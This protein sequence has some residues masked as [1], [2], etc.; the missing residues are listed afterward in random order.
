MNKERTRFNKSLIGL[1][2]GIT[3]LFLSGAFAY[4]QQTDVPFV[5]TPEEVVMEMLKMA[6]V[7][8]NDLLYDLG[9]GDGRIVITAAKKFGCRGV[10]IDIDPQRIR[11]SR[12]NAIKEGVTDKVNFIQ[13]NLFNADISKATVVTL[14]LLSE[15]NLR[16]RPILF[17]Q[18]KPGTRVVSHEFSMGKWEADASTTVK[19][20][21]TPVVDYW[22]QDVEDYWNTHN[23]LFWIMPANVTGT[24][25]LTVPDI[26][27]KNEWVLKFNQEFQKVSGK[28]FEDNTEIPLTVE[29]G[30][31][32]GD[33]LH[34]TLERR[35]R[36]RMERMHFEGSVKDHSMNGI[37]TID[38]GRGNENT[39]WKATRDP[40]TLRPIHISD[41]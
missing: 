39:Q 10:G 32:N 15:V 2:A 25:E 24:W 41:Y 8:K 12:E 28:A 18:L 9:C 26:T 29:G 3:L 14:Y 16:L 40:S 21:E 17:Q 33:K 38:R 31:V 13:M 4:V 36:G 19:T 37:V 11:E 30:K 34:F 6:N 27:G 5:P 22:R 20:G 1:F 23:V 35:L 7:G